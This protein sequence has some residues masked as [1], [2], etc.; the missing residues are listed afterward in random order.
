MAVSNASLVWALLFAA[1]LMNSGRSFVVHHPAAVTRAS[2]SAATT[3]RHGVATLS[4]RPSRSRSGG[5]G[6]FRTGW[7]H[8]VGMTVTAPGGAAAGGEIFRNPFAAKQSLFNDAFTASRV[9]QA[10]AAVTRAALP[11]LSTPR[12]VS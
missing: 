3:T 2:T 8:C 11:L 4:A 10:L 9:S 7:S 6:E 1:C 5:G 12:V